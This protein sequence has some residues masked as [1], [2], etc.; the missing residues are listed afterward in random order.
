[1][2]QE[3]AEVRARHLSKSYKKLVQH[4]ATEIA[5]TYDGTHIMANEVAAAGFTWVERRVRKAG[6]A[7]EKVNKEAR[8]RIDEIRGT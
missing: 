3:A 8:R 7:I 6:E 4:E 1:M 5:H 2:L